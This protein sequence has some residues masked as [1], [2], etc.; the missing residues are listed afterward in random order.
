MKKSIRLLILSS[1]LLSCTFMSCDKDEEECIKILPSLGCGQ[2]LIPYDSEEFNTLATDPLSVKN[3]RLEQTC[4]IVDFAYSGCKI[5][6]VG[7]MAFL[8]SSAFIPVIYAKI[9]NLD[10]QE[11][12]LAH[13]SHTDTFDLT[14]IDFDLYNGMTLNVHEWE[15]S[16]I[17][18]VD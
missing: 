14:T 13:F 5:R 10:P 8:D 6:D 4:L 1:L 7:V 15:N 3:M 17:L 2:D 18:D 11:A 9:S 12:C 16:F